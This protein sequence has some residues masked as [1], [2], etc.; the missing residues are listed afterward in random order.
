M[1]THELRGPVEKG[2]TEGLN[3]LK[4]VEDRAFARGGAA[5]RPGLD[6]KVRQ[7]VVRQ[8]HQTAGTR[9]DPW[10]RTKPW[11]PRRAWHMATLPYRHLGS[12]LFAAR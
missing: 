10:P 6:L 9:C 8:D 7:Q 3:R 1:R 2:Q 5:H 4:R 12:H 11:T